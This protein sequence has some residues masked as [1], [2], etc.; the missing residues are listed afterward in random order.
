MHFRSLEHRIV[1]LFLI[2]ILAVQATGFV[3][4]RTGI[5]SNARKA[6]R[7]ELLISEKV[8]RRLL[9]QNAQRLTQGAR[10]LAADYGFR[11]AIASNERETISSALAN[12]GARIGASQTLLI[13]P[14]RQITATTAAQPSATLSAST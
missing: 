1:S 4:I 10:L 5:D 9:D 12:H 14:E 13:G 3:V 6:I 7:S 2:L 8:F 11:Q